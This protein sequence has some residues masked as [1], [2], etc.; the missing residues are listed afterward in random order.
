MAVTELVKVQQCDNP[1]DDQ[2][3]EVHARVV[4]AVKRM[5]EQNR[6]EEIARPLV[7]T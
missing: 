2:V 1:T 6:P 3:N 4:E 7:V 5:Y